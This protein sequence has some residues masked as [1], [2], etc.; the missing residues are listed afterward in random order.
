MTREF[1]TYEMTQAEH[2]EITEESEMA[3]QDP[4]LIL[5]KAARA[6]YDAHR[7]DRL[8]RVWNR[9]ADRVGCDPATIRE[10]NHGR[11]FFEAK[12]RVH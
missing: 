4:V 5:T 7:H 11:L 2:D 1:R 12:P 6:H 10:S 8:L 3:R 9:I